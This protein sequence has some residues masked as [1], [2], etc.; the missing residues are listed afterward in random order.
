MPQEITVKWS[1]ELEETQGPFNDFP[2]GT[3]GCRYQFH[4]PNTD[5]TISLFQFFL[6]D[7]DKRMIPLIDISRGYTANE[8]NLLMQAGL[9]IADHKDKIYPASHLPPKFNA[10]WNMT[11]EQFKELKDDVIAMDGDDR[12]LGTV[13]IG[14]IRLSLDVESK[15]TR[16]SLGV[17]PKNQRVGVLLLATGERSDGFA[18]YTDLGDFTYDEL[19][20]AMKGHFDSVYDLTLPGFKEIVEQWIVDNVHNSNEFKNG[21]IDDSVFNRPIPK[22]R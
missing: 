13:D 11:K 21:E 4:D 3:L 9:W 5:T 22:W 19:K 15:E 16:R 1:K 14:G 18:N 17:A 6:P 8:F 2:K 12:I 10:V 7:G 20:K